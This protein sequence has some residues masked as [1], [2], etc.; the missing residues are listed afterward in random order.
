MEIRFRQLNPYASRTYL[1]GTPGAGEVVLVDPVLE[2]VGE[3]KA[4]LETEKLTLTHV[5]DTH[6][7]ADHISGAAA[8][9]LMQAGFKRVYVLAGGMT[10]WKELG[11]PVQHG[12]R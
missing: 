12:L 5:I 9:V 8:Q 11:L 7:H 4:L 2:H 6:T 1:A 10:R 3:Y